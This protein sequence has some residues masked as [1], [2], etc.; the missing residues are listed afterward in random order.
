MS[1][2]NKRLTVAEIKYKNRL[3]NK[4]IDQV[5][6]LNGY[7]QNNNSVSNLV[8]SQAQSEIEDNSTS[9]FWDKSIVTVKEGTYN[10]FNGVFDFFEGLTD[11]SA[12]VVG[13]IGSWFGNEDLA[14]GATD[15]INYDWS[16]AGAKLANEAGNLFSL[17][18]NI[19]NGVNNNDWSAFTD[20]DATSLEQYE[21]DLYNNGLWDN[22]IDWVNTI[23]KGANELI[24]TTA[25]MLPS[26]ALGALTGGTSFAATGG[27]ALSNSAVLGKILGTGAQA[28]SKAVSVGAMALSAAGQGT[29]E[30][31]QDGAT[32]DKATGYG[33]AAG[34]VEG[35]TEY[36][37]GWLGEIAGAGAKG[38]SKLAGNSQALSKLGQGLKTL[39]PNT[40]SGLFAQN[41]SK[42]M[43]VQ[44]AK[45]FIEEGTEEVLSDLVNPMI[46]SIYNGKSIRE[47][48]A[49]KD[50][51]SLQG[52]TE[53]FIMGGLSTL[54]LGGA[55]IV[56][57]VKLGKEGR[58]LIDNLS[59]NASEI[60]TEITN[61]SKSE[62]LF[63]IDE[64]GNKI[65]T[66][67]GAK[68]LEKERALQDQM[69][70]EFNSL[71]DKQKETLFKTLT[72]VS[73]TERNKQLNKT[74]DKVNKKLASI[75]TQM[76]NISDTAKGQEL[77][78]DYAYFSNYKTQIEN[79]IKDYNESKKSYL[80]N[81]IKD[82]IDNSTSTSKNVGKEQVARIKEELE[83]IGINN[84]DI[85]IPSQEE[86]N[87]LASQSNANQETTT[88]VSL[89]SPA[90][91]EDG[92]YTIFIN[93]QY[94]VN[95]A[96]NITHEI[97]H[98]KSA[99]DKNYT[100]TNINSYN[101]LA[102]QNSA[103]KAKYEQIIKDTLSN[104][105]IDDLFTFGKQSLEDYKGSTIEYVD[106]I[107]TPINSVQ[108]IKESAINGVRSNFAQYSQLF[109][110]EVN[111]A[112]TSFNNELIANVADSFIDSENDLTKTLNLTQKNK[113]TR[114]LKLAFN[115]D[116][117]FL[118][119]FSKNTKSFV[120]NQKAKSES[121]S[122]SKE[123]TL[124]ETQSNDKTQSK[125][126]S[127][128]GKTLSDEFDEA[129]ENKKRVEK[130]KKEN[131]VIHDK[132]FA[133]YYSDEFIEERSEQR[134]IYQHYISKIDVDNFKDGFK[135]VSN[136]I[137]NIE[138]NL[139]DYN[140][141]QT[142]SLNNMSDLVEAT[143]L[144]TNFIKDLS[145]NVSEVYEYLNENTLV[146]S[147]Y[148]GINSKARQLG[149][150]IS[151]EF[152]RVFELN[153]LKYIDQALI[154]N[155]DVE[156]E[157]INSK[158]SALEIA[159]D[160]MTKNGWLI[161][162]KDGN[163]AFDKE[164][165]LKD[166]KTKTD[167]ENIVKY[168]DEV[169][170]SDKT[171][172]EINKVSQEDLDTGF[173][174]EK[175]TSPE[176]K[177]ARAKLV[178]EYNNFVDNIRNLQYQYK[179][180]QN[181]NK[182]FLDTQK[183]KSI[184][185]EDSELTRMFSTADRDIAYKESFKSKDGDERHRNIIKDKK[186][187]ALYTIKEVSTRDFNYVHQVE[188]NSSVEN[189][190]LL[191]PHGKT[192]EEQEGFYSS[193]NRT[194][195]AIEDIDSG[196]Y[197]Y[198]NSRPANNGQTFVIE[199]ISNANSN[200]IR[201]D[202]LEN[203]IENKFNGKNIV[204]TETINN[205]QNKQTIWE[206][207]SKFVKT[208]IFTDKKSFNTKTAFFVYD[209][210][211][212]TK[213]VNITPIKTN[214]YNKALSSTYTF[215]K[216][217]EKVI[218]QT[219][220]ALDILNEKSRQIDKLKASTKVVYDVVN[221]KEVVDS[222]KLTQKEQ[223]LKNVVDENNN[224][225]LIAEQGTELT[226]K[227]KE[228]EEQSRLKGSKQHNPNENNGDMVVSKDTVRGGES[229]SGGIGVSEQAEARFNNALD[230]YKNAKTFKERN[231]AIK[232][233]A[234]ST[235]KVA[236][237]SGLMLKL[238]IYFTDDKAGLN[239]L[240]RQIEL[241]KNYEDNDAVAQLL[242]SE[243]NVANDLKVKGFSYV[244][245]SGKEVKTSSLV[246]I[247]NLLSEVT[248]KEI[249]KHKE[250]TKKE[251]REYITKVKQEFNAYLFNYLAI[252]RNNAKVVYAERA[253]NEL[254]Q[255]LKNESYKIA[256]KQVNQ[257]FEVS[258]NFF[259]KFKGE[260]S[261]KNT[262]SEQDIINLFGDI[263]AKINEVLKDNTKTEKDTIN[264]L[265]KKRLA[266]MQEDGQTDTKL[267]YPKVLND[268]LFGSNHSNYRKETL[269]FYPD[270]INDIKA[271]FD[272]GITNIT[273]RQW[274]QLL[275]DTQKSEL[276]QKA[277]KKTEDGKWENLEDHKT[278][279]DVNK[280]LNNHVISYS[281][282]MLLKAN[283]EY[284]K[285]YGKEI[286]K[287]WQ[288][289]FYSYAKGYREMAFTENLISRNDI[290]IMETLYPHYVPTQRE[291][292]SNRRGYSQLND[293][294]KNI[295]KAKGSEQ[296]IKDPLYVLSD[297]T[298]ALVRNSTTNDI[299]TAIR[300]H[301]NTNNISNAD[302]ETLEFL[303]VDPNGEGEI[304]NRD[305]LPKNLNIDQF[306]RDANE[307]IE[308]GQQ[309]LFKFDDDGFTITTMSID[310]DGTKHYYIS[311]MTEE[312]YTAFS[313]TSK[314][315]ANKYLNNL[316]IFKV[317][318][319]GIA[320]FKNL[321]TSYSPMF[322]GRNL[323]R[324]I[325]DAL[326]T[327]KNNAGAFIK[328]LPKSWKQIY[329]NSELWQTYVKLGGVV[330]S[331]FNSYMESMEKQALK[332]GKQ[333]VRVF[334]KPIEF[335]ER[336]NFITEQG[337]RFTEFKLSYDRY[338]K[339]GLS[340]EEAGIKAV[341]DAQDVTTNFSKGGSFAKLLNSNL[342][343]FL[344]AQIQG[345]C[346]MVHF[347]MRPKDSKEWAKL[348]ITAFFLGIAPQ[349]LNELCYF[350]DEEYEALPEYTKENYYLIRTTNGDF[351]KIPK[352]RIVG[353]L[354]SITR[355]TLN[356]FTGK[357]DIGTA[358]KQT[359]DTAVSNLSPVDTS[360]GL[361]TIF[362]PIKD[363]KTNTTWYGQSI[364]K[365]SDLNKRPSQ[366]YDSKTG[367]IAK[368][369]GSMFNYSPKKIQYLLEQYTGIVG[370][371]LLPIGSEST[372]NGSSAN[373][374]DN[375]L[376]I[377]K[378]NTSIDA[379]SNNKYSGEFYDLR[380]QILY[381][382]NEGDSV[383]TLQYS[384]M[385][386]ALNEIDELEE[387]LDSTNNEAERYTLYLTIRQA[388]KQA[389]ENT[390]L[391]GT[392]LQNISIGE[393]ADKFSLAEAYRQCFGAEY[394]LKYYSTNLYDKAT[395]INKMGVSYDEYYRAYF[396][397]R[398]LS[399]KAERLKYINKIKGLTYYARKLLY[400]TCGGALNKTEKA[401]LYR[402]MTRLGFTE[403]DLIAVGLLESE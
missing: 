351:I 341:H 167:I 88:Q 217:K 280:N 32:I 204:L 165:M 119:T 20:L 386:R 6:E 247:R 228:A 189:Q 209:Q 34:A 255:E 326:L 316:G 63:T 328:E 331:E 168:Y 295:Y 1:D 267:V 55:D 84:F 43:F 127:K 324:D 182:S 251:R 276:Y 397:L 344:N 162:D 360:S 120:E 185:T 300:E 343:P 98:L 274:Q 215:L 212:I 260:N 22:S 23:H 48:Y 99:I 10:F 103:F 371:V 33:L 183:N 256:E 302:F 375:L 176:Y 281:N 24:T 312:I 186:G 353:T 237:D 117:A 193:N 75:E 249:L 402:Y 142:I 398:N 219:Q 199:V 166:G 325:P 305:I 114:A 46:K 40:V 68:V 134:T 309:A 70:N 378:N 394:A 38:I 223:E 158:E 194:S 101:E 263:R 358:I 157:S 121:V 81:F 289:S 271:L 112:R 86:F 231:N 108:Y 78:N 148:V 14:K 173:K 35:V 387:Q 240:C 180:L 311:K 268:D 130:I 362:A 226:K 49:D 238:Q 175:D 71:N 152:K 279:V 218:K 44:V 265:I 235:S 170:E 132:L 122:A 177:E 275:E 171:N 333:G 159:T 9:S 96:T 383:A 21:N 308:E 400:K 347:V 369:L 102:K 403:E 367:T 153:R 116:K 3:Q 379:I 293:T 363:I 365:Q 264:N 191:Y 196:T 388:Y 329:S 109:N 258:N 60:T 250:W 106:Y 239:R 195:Y 93:P 206:N 243:P 104:Y 377:I 94:E 147:Q 7:N 354:N 190:K 299:I 136:E 184:Q 169:F 376:S 254:K 181:K 92:T 178:E 59:N 340:V 61:L 124:V 16:K 135:S 253:I 97:E 80:N 384:Y 306:V 188:R 11:F 269:K 210:K 261:L 214:D 277:I 128:K 2:Y 164:K 8:N 323:A 364:D 13:T 79:Q 370:D 244:D 248:D 338:I 301:M 26:I 232:E 229:P 197:L 47:N 225:V 50:N 54:V 4:G 355:Q 163:Y 125:A 145:K 91:N 335:F 282:E 133:K 85:K 156:N 298:D 342:V 15:F 198:L 58:S 41:V 285:K 336:L 245:S 19:A 287:K 372:T 66:Q 236:S 149:S 179:T 213:N 89:F 257:L 307:S 37:L 242:R 27:T 224:G 113:L 222:E 321:V 123:K 297:M 154:D 67:D 155:I 172:I 401:N 373:I 288:D 294:T 315:S 95:I 395:V 202:L 241:Y 357:S 273:E 368:T 246:D 320:L 252:D 160:F 73:L 140:G 381:K 144:A 391:I 296:V 146:S 65:P 72:N 350:N 36:A 382:K 90:R 29:Q 283:E 317:I 45:E 303:T 385:T 332:G 129:S 399:T 322:V 286:L 327:T 62:N 30:A 110:K 304:I 396:E 361:R 366:R 141:K 18:Y 284:E 111:N 200:K 392:K 131:K 374:G 380:T 137:K 83:K 346:K 349:L 330:E 310:E 390:K 319:K 76:N 230:N 290:N 115:K 393:D 334:A 359:A 39:F 150:E 234:K 51:F 126:I 337:T 139:V 205:N 5:S 203:L 352:G 201:N 345:A 221:A 118:E 211:G 82:V 53:S 25:N 143:N 69:L 87:K 174:V 220:K 31:I 107:F 28:V 259:T 161:I 12:G 291:L 270:L 262:A 52:L 314:Y 227:I 272:T 100:R 151:K 17:T 348:I 356:V 233:L 77:A 216:N 292:V 208:A 42:S 313:P 207:S 57:G 74:Y 138:S 187:N 389:I 64:N 339:N 278:L 318:R 56:N 105:Q 192:L 266:K